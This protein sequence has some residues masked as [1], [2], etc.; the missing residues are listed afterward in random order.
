MNMFHR[1]VCIGQQESTNR[2]FRSGSF[3]QLP[4]NVHSKVE[5]F[6]TLLG[7]IVCH[8]KDRPAADALRVAWGIRNVSFSFSFSVSFRAQ[9]ASQYGAGL[10]KVIGQTE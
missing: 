2:K 10:F 3:G 7:D 5:V 8:G 9:G 1:P 4:Q 6:E